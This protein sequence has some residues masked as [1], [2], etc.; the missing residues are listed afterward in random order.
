M[1]GGKLRA[2][3]G[4]DTPFFMDNIDVARGFVGPGDEPVQMGK[5]MSRIIA[6]FARTG[7]PDIKGEPHWPAFNTQTRETMLFAL[8]LKVVH[9]PDAD[10]R[11]LWA[12]K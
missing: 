5:A 7:V 6:A 4:I 2:A 11:M 10:T 12:A 9:D 8:P 3:H 1:L